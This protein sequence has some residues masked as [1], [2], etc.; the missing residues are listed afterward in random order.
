M[1]SA[2]STVPSRS[3]VG[4][5]T[6][7]PV[8]RT[9]IAMT[10]TYPP[11]QC[12][13]ATFSR[14]L[15]NALVEDADVDVV[16]VV[17][18]D[19]PSG[20][21]REVTTR[22]FGGER[23][24]I[25]AVL[26]AIDGV[27]LL[28]VQHEFGIYGGR[29]GADVIELLEAVSAPTIVVLHT[30]LGNPSGHQRAV[31]NRVTAAADRV[32]VQSAVARERIL[33]SVDVDPERLIVI[34]HG[35]ALNLAGPR[36]TLA[37]GPCVLTW[38]LLGPGKGIEHGIRALA[39]LGPGEPSPT[40]VVLGGTHPKVFEREGDAY[41][42]SLMALA[43][44]LHVA[45]RVRFDDGYRDT[46]E[47]RACVRAADVILL[48]YDSRDQ[49]T[50]GVLVEALAAGKPVVATAFPHAVEAL[51]C[52]AGIVVPHG[53]P[54]AMAGALGVALFDRSKGDV[55]RAAA[56]AEAPHLDWSCVAARYL[57]LGQTI[58]KQAV[59]A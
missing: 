18:R 45:D 57:E 31:L 29:D 12:G 11:T 9:R 42:Q 52:G 53:D 49:V 51:A 1:T 28:I 5:G 36:P 17:G 43:D 37:P 56:S 10:G 58:T 38:G 3:T 35:A 25:P 14:S 21:A 54:V 30:A 7:R 26:R 55:M 41:R 34:P 27:D 2:S 4:E 8:R 40:Y 6:V 50:S 15:R 20:D 16:R 47:L 39:A 13:L 44:Q 46:D 33:H 22:W 23:A 19:V 59:A 32:V 48:P 24:G